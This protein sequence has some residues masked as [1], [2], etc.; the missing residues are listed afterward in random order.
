[1]TVTHQGA[2]TTKG[3]RPRRE[4]FTA[5]LLLLWR[6]AARDIVHH[7]TESLL[8]LSLLATSATALTVAFALSNVADRPYEQTKVATAGPDVIA[9]VF[10]D[11][12][13]AVAH[14]SRSSASDAAAALAATSASAG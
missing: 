5:R 7:R 4:S 14:P 3:Q 1:M 11:V 6:M 12:S 13:T 2:N 8:I 10:S 9:N